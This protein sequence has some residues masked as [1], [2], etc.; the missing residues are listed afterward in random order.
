MEKLPVELLLMLLASAARLAFRLSKNDPSVADC[1]GDSYAFGIA[2]TGGTSSSSSAE[3]ELWL[4]GVNCLGAGRRDALPAAGARGWIDEPVEVLMVLKL[5]VEVMD[6]PELYDFLCMSGVVRDDDGV[7]DAFRGIIDGDLEC[8][9]C[10]S[11]GG[12]GALASW[13]RLGTWCMDMRF[14]R[15]VSVGLMVLAPRPLACD[16]WDP[17]PGITDCLLDCEWAEPPAPP[18]FPLLPPRGDRGDIVD[19]RLLSGVERFVVLVRGSA[20]CIDL[21]LVALF[22]R[23]RGVSKPAP[24]LPSIEVRVESSPPPALPMMLGLLLLCAVR[25][26]KSVSMGP[27]PMDFLGGFAMLVMMVFDTGG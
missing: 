26:P 21:A 9:R 27:G 10:S 14:I 25:L 13:V 22:V 12:G 11:G 4:C 23:F 7:A 8:S 15:R 19:R 6:K 17:P 18:V 16:A 3:W 1:C 20:W 2:G 24:E 5:L